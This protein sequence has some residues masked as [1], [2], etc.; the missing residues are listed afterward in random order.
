MTL[1]VLD[2]SD[3][4][5]GYQVYRRDM[6]DLVAEIVRAVRDPGPAQGLWLACMNPHSYAVAREQAAFAQALRSARWLVP[7]GTGIVLASRLLH[8]RIA[9][10]LTG[11][12]LFAAVSA[13]LDA[14]GPF[15]V[16][17]MGADSATLAAIDQRYRREHPNAQVHVHAPPYRVQFSEAEIAEMAAVIERC[18][19]D[20]LWLGLTAPKQE[21]LLARLAP[22]AGFRFGAG[23]GAAFDFYVGKVRR[24]PPVFQRLGLEW[25][26]R[27][28]Q[29]PRRLWRRMFVSAP[30]FLWDVARAARTGARATQ[31][32]KDL[33]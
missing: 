27:L 9:Q 2:T 11:P 5:L 15:R 20:V 24:S 16:L 12:D 29:Q 26:P 18:R 31:L 3:S 21:L 8:G 28:V 4:L 33:P 23:V 10:R 7:D 32:K 6:H 13:G 1:P 14:G 30:V 25:L 17:F 19:P 22:R